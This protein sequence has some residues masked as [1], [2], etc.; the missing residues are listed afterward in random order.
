MTVLPEAAGRTPAPDVSVVIVSFNVK[1]LLAACLRSVQ[2][3][4]SALACE[5]FVV[6]NASPDGSADMV[7]RDFPGVTLIRNASN[8]WLAPANNQALERCAGRTILFLNP[9]TELVR[10]ALLE[11]LRYLDTHRDVGMVGA[12][13]LNSDGS[14]QPSGNAFRPAWSYLTD[15]L[16]LGR[17]GFSRSRDFREHGRD[18]GET[19]DVDEV[20]GAC[21]LMSDDAGQLDPDSALFAHSC[22]TSV[23]ASGAGV[24][25]PDG[26]LAG[27]HLG[28]SHLD[29]NIGQQWQGMVL[30][31][32][33]VPS[34]N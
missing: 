22:D 1:V 16:P 33:G 17:L 11:L 12:Q 25:L 18:Y 15:A 26:R 8:R 24:L 28:A 19:R 27:I 10:G 29:S 13:L 23:S 3:D 20:S 21:A 5:I 7:A 31:D 32:G 4:A 14:L 9:D 30:G 6:D 2:A 34:W